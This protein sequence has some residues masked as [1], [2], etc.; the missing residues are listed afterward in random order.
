MQAHA[1]K[2]AAEACCVQLLNEAF[3][4]DALGH[5]RFS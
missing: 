1:G 2:I 5:V 4:D 3:R